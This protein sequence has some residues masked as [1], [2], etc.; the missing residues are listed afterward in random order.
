MG[1]SGTGLGMPMHLRGNTL[2]LLLPVVV[3]E[4][5]EGKGAS[6]IH[7]DVRGVDALRQGS[8]S[9]SELGSVLA[10]IAGGKTKI[11]I[12]ILSEERL[13][14]IRK[15]NLGGRGRASSQRPHEALAALLSQRLWRN[16][17]RRWSRT[18]C[19]LCAESICRRKRA[20]GLGRTLNTLGKGTA[21]VGRAVGATVKQTVKSMLPGAELFDHAKLVGG[22]SAALGL[23]LMAATATVHSGKSSR[24]FGRRCR[25]KSCGRI[26]C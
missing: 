13:S 2:G 15:G 23:R 21:S 16:W 12:H 26:D 8:H 9:G 6:A 5:L 17:P 3:Q 22:G 19:E 11:N 18:F 25:R 7:F 10:N 4:A 14:T 24:K 20:A 1:V